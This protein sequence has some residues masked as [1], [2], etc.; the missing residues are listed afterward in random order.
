[1]TQIGA[2]QRPDESGFTLIETLV[3][4]ALMG[5]VLSHWRISPRCGCRTGTAGSTGFSA[6]RRSALRCNESRPILRLPNS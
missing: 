5:L 1:M 2:R 3:A 4:L 6:A